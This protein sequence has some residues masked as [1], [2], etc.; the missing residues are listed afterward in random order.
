MSACGTYERLEM[1][2]KILVGKPEGKSGV[3]KPRHVD[4]IRVDFKEMGV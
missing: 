3:S 4:N 1:P 2:Y